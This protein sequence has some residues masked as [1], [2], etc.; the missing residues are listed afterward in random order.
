MSTSLAG[1][2]GRGMGRG[3]GWGGLGVGRGWKGDNEGIYREWVNPP[4]FDLMAVP[5]LYTTHPVYRSN[6]AL[7][8][9]A[10]HSLLDYIHVY[11]W[12]E[13]ALAWVV[14]LE[15]IVIGRAS[16]LQQGSRTKCTAQAVWP[17]TG[18]GSVHDAGTGS[19]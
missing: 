16:I 14:N 7:S 17:H 1:G 12:G 4:S 18:P 10:N 11:S 13:R 15:N 5:L 3:G 19:P 9:L 2:M 6:A 8:F